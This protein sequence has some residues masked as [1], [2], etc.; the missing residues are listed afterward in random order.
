MIT[1]YRIASNVKIVTAAQSA[2]IIAYSKSCSEKT[3]RI[4]SIT[5]EQFICP[6]IYYSKRVVHLLFKCW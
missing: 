6:T 4:F 2:K 1:I 5:Y 3:W